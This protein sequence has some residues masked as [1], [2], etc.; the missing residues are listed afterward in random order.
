MHKSDNGMGSVAAVGRSQ[1]HKE[2]AEGD[3]FGPWA[4]RAEGD[5]PVQGERGL[6]LNA[7]NLNL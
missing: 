6:K 2:M 3:A 1:S 4:D 5:E 7:I